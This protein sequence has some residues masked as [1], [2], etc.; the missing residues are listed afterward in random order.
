VLSNYQNIV[1]TAL[2]LVFRTLLCFIFPLTLDL[3]SISLRQLLLIEF[4]LFECVVIVVT[5]S[6]LPD[7]ILRGKFDE[8]ENADEQLGA[9]EVSNT[10]KLRK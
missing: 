6:F 7:F 5:Y 9:E 10:P 8:L 3:N 1:H 2:N 4:S